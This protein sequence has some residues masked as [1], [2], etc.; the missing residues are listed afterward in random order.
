M[1]PSTVPATADLV[2][3]HGDAL[4]SSDLQLRQYGGLR[5]FTGTVRTVRCFQD[6]ALVKQVLATP[7]EGQVLVVDGDGSLHSALMGDLIAASAVAHGWAGVVV[8]GAVRDVAALATC[9]WASRPWVQPAQ[10]RQERRRRGRRP[11]RL[12]WRD[13]P[14]R[15][16]ALERRRRHRRAGRVHRALTGVREPPKIGPHVY[17]GLTTISDDAAV[18][19]AGNQPAS[20]GDPCFAPSISSRPGP[21]CWPWASWCWAC[22]PARWSR[23]RAPGRPRSRSGY[24][25]F[26]YSTSITAPTGQ[27]PESK[28]WYADGTWWGALWNNT[29]RR[30]GDPPVQPG[31]AGHQRLDARPA[32]SSTAAAT[33][34]PTPSGTA[35]S[36]T[37]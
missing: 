4:A 18:R 1:D 12:R 35:A 37:C 27:K 31:H 7:G 9:R 11:G 23:R 22:W 34:R 21:G 17:G 32:R 14:P 20:Q 36:S 5:S 15:P 29:V 3:Q 13:L 25:D 16:A 28:L 19:V 6:N 33:P 30:A 24:R 2:D 8:H 26:S 10:E